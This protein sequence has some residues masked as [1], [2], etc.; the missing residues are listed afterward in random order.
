[1]TIDQQAQQIRRRLEEER[2]A[3]VSVA[4]FGQ[5]GAGKSSLI[6]R[7]VG[8]KVTEVGV[9]TDKTVD[10]ARY[11]HN[12]LVLVDLPGYGTQ[13]F[14]KAGYAEQF[15]IR[16]LD[17]FLCV[18]S[19]KLHQADTELFQELRRL[20]KACIFVVNKHDELWE[21]GVET[22]ELERRKRADIERHVGAG[23]PVVFTNCRLRTGLD[24]LQQLI[25]ENLEAAKRERWMRGARAYS[26]EFLVAK[27]AA[28]E[29][30]VA[31]AAAA[32]A[33]NGL[34]PVPGADVAV[35]I[36]ILVRLF[37][38][39]REGYGLSSER[40]GLLRQSTIPAVA[41]LASNVLKYAAREGVLT[42]LKRQIGR[43]AAKSLA[44][45][46]PFIGQAIA[47]GL[48]YTITSNAGAS[49]LEECHEL[50]AQILAHRLEV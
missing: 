16:E 7:L 44:R 9:E 28:C 27:H 43:Q 21:E 1:M 36:G 26:A 41:Q 12:G 34:N 40:L 39:I 3:T 8:H 2:A 25:A 30:Y 11:E 42:L 22:H 19:G 4:L 6:N 13:R 15:R 18:T 50:A 17:L 29:K 20:G 37:S 23:V 49:Y 38:E 47:A 45:Y 35:D 14:P 48:G 5:P 31:T 32:S 46:V 10:A 33:A 24:T